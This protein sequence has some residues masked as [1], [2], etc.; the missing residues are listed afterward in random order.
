MAIPAIYLA[1][2]YHSLPARVPVHFN[3]SGTPDRYGSPNELIGAVAILSFLSI[4]VYLLLSYIYLIDPKKNALANRDRLQRLAFVVAVFLSAIGCLVIYSSQAGNTKNL[5]GLILASVGILF[6]FIGN[7]MPNLKPNY[8][9]GLRLPWTL[10]N[11]DNWKR[12]HQLAGK[13]WFGG[14]I[15]IAVLCI[16]LPTLPALILFFTI[17]SVIIIIPCIYSYR[18]YKSMKRGTT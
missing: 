18:L 7:Y 14:G 15:V 3:L 5:G 16:F 12:T 11:P 4:G 10:E 2:V 13:L 6:A 17:L 1:I 8:F 9:A